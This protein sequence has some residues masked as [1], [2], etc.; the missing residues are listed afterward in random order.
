MAAVSFAY[1][2]VHNDRTRTSFNVEVD[3]QHGSGDSQTTI[4]NSAKAYA[5][6]YSDARGK[7]ITETGSTFASSGTVR[8]STIR[9]HVT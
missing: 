5:K 7:G 8:V 2:V 4:R 3:V 1:R 6:R 9:F